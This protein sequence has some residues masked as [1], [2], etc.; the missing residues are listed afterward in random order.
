MDLL[1][2]RCFDILSVFSVVCPCF[3]L[4]VPGVVRIVG[5][6]GAGARCW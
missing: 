3:V 1:R 4:V 5:V 2:G 6:V